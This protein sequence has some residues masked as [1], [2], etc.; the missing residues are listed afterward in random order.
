MSNEIPADMPCQAEADPSAEPFTGSGQQT[1]NTGTSMI[2]WWYRPSEKLP[3]HREQV[4]IRFNDRVEVA[5][6][7]AALEQFILRNG[8]G[9][10]GTRDGLEW[11][12]MLRAEWV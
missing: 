10:L 7:D 3:A 5:V 12:E 8:N 11:M 6:Y 2:R 1:K 9:S 4:L